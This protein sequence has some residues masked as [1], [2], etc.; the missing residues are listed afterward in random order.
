MLN[1]QTKTKLLEKAVLFILICWNTSIWAKF[2]E[3]SLNL[4][5]LSTISHVFC[6]DADCFFPGM[7]PAESNIYIEDNVD[8]DRDENLI[9]HTKRNIIF[10][11]NGKII[12]KKNGSIILKSGMLPGE[13]EIYDATVKFEGNT[14][15]IEMLGEGKIKIYYNPKKGGKKHKYHNPTVYNNK[16]PH[17]KLEVYLLINDVYDLQGITAC[18]Y[19]VYALSQDIDA[20]LTRYWNNGQGFFPI[21]DAKSGFPFSGIFDGNNHTIK[22]LYINRPEEEWVGLFGD[23]TGV[24]EY[25][26][27]L[28]NFTIENAEIYGKR[29]VGVTIGQA[30]GVQIS[31]VNVV[32]SIYTGRYSGQIAG[33]V[34]VNTHK[35]ISAENTTLYKNGEPEIEGS[36]LFGSCVGCE[37]EENSDLE[38]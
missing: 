33:C 19:G 24:N 13:Q 31:N 11:D 18:L 7:F 8:W 16:L 1:T 35:L 27:I 30:T 12:S 9:L 37:E 2:N 15:P 34:L 29:C 3:G 6:T 17:S 38:K 21:K 36:K 32:N 23:V 14:I 4:L 20:S 25:R 26:S 10:K 22:N 5:D 28:K